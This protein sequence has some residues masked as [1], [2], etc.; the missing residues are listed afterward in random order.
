MNDRRLVCPRRSLPRPRL[1][2][3][4][5]AGSVLLFQLLGFFMP[6]LRYMR[7]AACINV[8][9]VLLALW[10]LWVPQVCP[11]GAVI[12]LFKKTYVG[13]APCIQRRRLASQ[14][15]R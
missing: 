12:P 4:T 8:I 15:P 7:A 11:A 5:P 3:P 6:P 1:P 14:C 2:C 10:A 13:G 9:A